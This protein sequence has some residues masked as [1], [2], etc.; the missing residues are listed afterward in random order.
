MNFKFTDGNLTQHLEMNE[1]IRGRRRSKSV[2]GETTKNVTFYSPIEVTDVSDIDKRL[3]KFS[4]NHVTQ[5]RKRSKS[6]DNPFIKSRIPQPSKPKFFP[7]IKAPTPIKL[8]TRTKLPNFAAI[9]QKQFN[10]MESLVDHVERKAVRAKELTNSARKLINGNASAQ[11][12]SAKKFPTSNTMVVDR[13]RPQAVKKIM[14]PPDLLTPMKPEEAQRMK[15]LPTPRNIIV[16]QPKSRLPLL[17]KSVTKI[18]SGISTAPAPSSSIRKPVPDAAPAPIQ[19][20]LEARRQRHM[21]MFKG[22]TTK[23]NKRELIRGVRSNRRFELQMQHRR[24]MDEN[25]T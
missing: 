23:E 10:K 16:V 17:A 11:K 4:N 9:H 5:R 14:L 6:L 13:P 15:N 24:Q 2:C 20:K 22:R 25:N 12:S 18:F 3:E 8:K 7:V 1:S 21:E 19:S